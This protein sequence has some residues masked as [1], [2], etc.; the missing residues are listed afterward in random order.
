MRRGGAAMRTTLKLSPRG[1]ACTI[2]S[3]TASAAAP[4]VVSSATRGLA[5]RNPNRGA[6]VIKTIPRG[7]ALRGPL[8]SLGPSQ[9]VGQVARQGDAQVAVGSQLH[10]VNVLVPAAALQ[11]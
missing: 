6:D 4:A 8:R 2:C 3:A 7:A 10:V 11:L 9:A 1:D 5:N